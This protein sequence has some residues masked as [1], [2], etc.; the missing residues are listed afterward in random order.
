MSES[1]RQIFDAIDLDGRAALK[2]KIAVGGFLAGDGIQNDQ[3]FSQRE[4]FGRGQAARFGEDQIGRGHQFV[5]VVGKSQQ[6][7]GLPARL[8]L[9]S[10]SAASTPLSAFMST[11]PLRQ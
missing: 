6:M 1:K 11:G 5:H 4:R 10:Q 2:Q 7:S 8:A 9:M 3:R